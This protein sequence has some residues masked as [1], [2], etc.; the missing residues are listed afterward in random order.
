MFTFIWNPSFIDMTF[1][2]KHLMLGHVLDGACLRRLTVVCFLIFYFIYKKYFPTT[3]TASMACCCWQF[4]YASL[5][6][7]SNLV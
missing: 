7:T 2:V 3:L 1:K 5:N 4:F 6:E